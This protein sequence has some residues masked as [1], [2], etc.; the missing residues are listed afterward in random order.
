MVARFQGREMPLSPQMLYSVVRI[1]GDKRDRKTGRIKREPLGTGF[2]IHVPREKHD[3]AWYGYLITAHHVIDGQPNLDLIFPDPYKP[4]GLYPAVATSGPDWKQPLEGVDLAVLPFARPDGYWINALQLGLHL[5]EHLPGETMLARPFHYVGLLEPLNRAMVRSGTLGAIYEK[6]IAH[7]DG[8]VYDAHLGDCRTYAGFSGS[9]CFLEIAM[10]G[11]TPADPQPPFAD[12]LLGNVGPVGVMAY[13]HLLCGMVTWHL[14]PPVEREEASIL[15]LVALL[16]S[17]DIWRAL[18][19]DELVNER[20]ELD[21]VGD[22]PEAVAVNLS[23][24]GS[25]AEGE[26]D[27]FEDLTDRLLRVPKTELDEKLKEA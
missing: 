6:G 18:M 19:S 2:H 16:T 10:P 11:V 17:D 23:T 3:D 12:E 26:F 8:Y 24:G 7:K 22:A 13:L 5:W 9:P 21:Q 14:E 4:G 20:R 27:S 25:L 1:I 15:G